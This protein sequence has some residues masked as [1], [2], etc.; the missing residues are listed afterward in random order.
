[1]HLTPLITDFTWIALVFSR[2]Q[3]LKWFESYP[4]N[5]KQF[6]TINGLKSDVKDIQFGVQQG[7]ESVTGKGCI[8]FV[9][10]A[11]TKS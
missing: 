4:H 7:S 8:E 2:G 6:V 10:I 1:M 3:V 5:G 9:A 11:L